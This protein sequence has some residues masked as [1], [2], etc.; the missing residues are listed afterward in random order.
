[1][2]W[3]RRIV[4]LVVTVG[5][6]WLLAKSSA[7]DV[8][9]HG[10]DAAVV[11]LSWVARPE[12]IEQCR[13]LTPE[14]LATRP[15]HMRQARECSGASATYRLSLAVD[16]ASHEDRVLRG[17]GLRNDRAIFVLDEFPVSPGQR[18]VV[19]R[20]ARVEPAEA[21]M[22][23]SNVR[24]GAVPRDL[25]LDTTVTLSASAV[26]LVALVDGRLQLRTP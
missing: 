3:R 26:A 8:R 18:R 10:A 22:D 5:F 12:R 20:F 17:G 23:S 13:D 6:G 7:A 16:G 19:I 4:A 1:M 11:R 15:A 14:E 2:T 24:R 25:T 9:W 21:P